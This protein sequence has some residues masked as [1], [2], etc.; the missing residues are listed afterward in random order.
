[1]KNKMKICSGVLVL[2]AFVPG[3][4]AA[5]FKPVGSDT[6]T[7]V[8]DY[9]EYQNRAE[10]L[11]SKD[12][13]LIDLHR[14]IAAQ[15]AP[16]MPI[17]PK[18][19]APVTFEGEDVLYNQRTGEVYAKGNVKITQMES[20]LTSME[21]NGNTKSADV[22]IEGKVHLLQV[23]NP[24]LRLDGYKTAYNYQ[25]KTGKMEQAVGK[26]EDEYIKG[27]KI[28]FYPDYVVIYNAT[29]T[30]CSAAKPDYRTTAEKIE[31]WPK[32]RMVMHNAKFWIKGTVVGSRKYYETKFGDNK[33]DAMPHMGYTDDDGF[34]VKQSFEYPLAD[35]VNAYI[36][37]NYYSKHD[38]KNVYGT[39]WD[40][41]YNHYRLEWGSFE[42]ENNHWI[43]KEPTFTYTQGRKIGIS[44]F[45]YYL[46]IEMGKWSDDNKT[47]WHKKYWL[48][49][50]RDAVNFGKTLHLYT[51]TE[52]SVTQESYDD[53][54]VNSWSYDAILL[55]EFDRRLSA[56][57][58]YHYTQNTVANTLFNY[59]SEDYAKKLEYGFSYR[60]GDK[61]RIVIGRNYDVEAKEIRD[62]DYYWY[63][64][65]HCAQMILRYREKRDQIEV[66]FQFLPW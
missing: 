23:A 27:D 63:H 26:I 22:Y 48:G 53:S 56:F 66:K 18:K 3:Y 9:I 1:M 10:R 2:L 38:F 55:K 49:L 47:S 24:R 30:K 45:N 11:T 65:L 60:L 59:D 6:G 16:K 37:V 41:G 62:V 31:I 36:D 14:E 33:N 5:G 15:P 19:P 12:K 54:T 28:E 13:E 58:G 4:A 35:K 50:N 8:L 34:Y 29:M 64:D 21:I 39:T 25:K 46:G 40:N 52:Y 42:D 61:D 57:T 44:P 43:D 20:R 17:D 32:D 51:N 7:E